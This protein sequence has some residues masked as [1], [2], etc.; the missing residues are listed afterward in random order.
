MSIACR[1]ALA[2]LGMMV[3]SGCGGSTSSDGQ[4]TGSGG[5]AGREEPPGAGTGGGVAVDAGSA[6]SAGTDRGGAHGV[7]GDGAAAG[8][9][10]VGGSAGSSEGRG[11]SAGSSEG[12]GGS[13]EGGGGSGGASAGH[14]GVSG[15]SG[16]DPTTPL[17]L[18]VV[19]L[20]IADTDPNECCA[21]PF[22]ATVE[23]VVADEWLV[24]YP[25]PQ[26][27]F[28]AM[29]NC[30]TPVPASRVA[31]PGPDG[32]CQFVDECETAEDCTTAINYR[33][34]CPCPEALPVDLVESDPCVATDSLPSLQCT[35]YA[36][37]YCEPCPTNAP[38]PACQDTDSG[39]MHCG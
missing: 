36:D 21:A 35:G 37:V 8:T 25:H 26:A 30:V 33:G 12:R 1:T 20:R 28:C 38:I 24:V 19:A 22:P 23:Q 7:G 13:S 4:S 10:M 11:G 6:A 39:Y 14:A 17:S 5:T 3:A 31:A 18:C 9:A 2:V 32:Q 29:V 15:G 34:W 16:V 27:D